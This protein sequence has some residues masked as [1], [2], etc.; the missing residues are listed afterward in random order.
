MKN[1]QIDNSKTYSQ[2][3]ADLHPRI[4]LLHPTKPILI[5]DHG[6]SIKIQD[7][8]QIDSRTTCPDDQEQSA[9][10]LDMPFTNKIIRIESL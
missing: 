4:K 9:V 3:L 10:Y 5:T 2:V 1:R 7:L 6:F 8:N